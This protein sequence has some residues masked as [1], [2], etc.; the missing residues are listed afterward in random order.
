MK[1]P[2]S[3]P[4]A[5]MEFDF[6]HLEVFC[7]VVELRS[8]SKAAREVFLAQ[9]SVSEKIA[10]LESIVGTRLLD[11]LG[12]Q[13]VPTKA[14]DLLYGHALRL[15]E[16]RHRA[17]LELQDFMGLKQGVVHVGG[18]TIPGEY[19]LPKVL[20]AFH[21][22]HPP[23]AVHL[24]IADSGD[25]EQAV[26]RGDL[27]LGIVGSKSAHKDLIHHVLW[28]DELVVA[29]RASHRWAARRQ[30]SPEE[31]LDEPF[32]FREIGSGTLKSIEAHLRVSRPMGIDSLRSAARLGTSTAVKEGIKAGLGV[33]ILSSRAIHT[34]LEAGVLTA[35]N[36]EGLPMTR[37][38]YLIRNK[39]RSMSPPCSALHEF[40]LTTRDEPEAP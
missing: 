4:R 19:I 24:T 30:I 26:L 15:L 27:E 7:K 2:D 17:S 21:R 33:S 31:L 5:S 11:R 3:P 6:R 35:L 22:T 38:F 16:M 34:E 18:S 39:T 23:I 32:I 14:G 36:L 25:I 1:T 13:V 12:R 37:S 28:N 9:A 10:A 40:L 20:G 8:F 29:V